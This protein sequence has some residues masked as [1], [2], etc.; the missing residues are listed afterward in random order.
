MEESLASKEKKMKAAASLLRDVEMSIPIRSSKHFQLSS[1]IDPPKKGDEDLVLLKKSDN[2]FL[3]PLDRTPYLT[4]VISQLHYSQKKPNIQAFVD[5]RSKLRKLGVKFPNEKKEAEGIVVTMTKF[6]EELMAN[7]Y[8]LGNVEKGI[9]V[10]KSTLDPSV[11]SLKL[12]DEN[13]NI[14]FMAAI[15]RLLCDY[16]TIINQPT[17]TRPEGYFDYYSLI[18]VGQKKPAE[19]AEGDSDISDDDHEDKK[20]N[21]VSRPPR[22]NNDDIIQAFIEE[23]ALNKIEPVTEA[24]A[25]KFV[26]NLAQFD[27]TFGKDLGVNPHYTENLVKAVELLIR[28]EKTNDEIVGPL[29]AFLDGNFEALFWLIENREAIMVEVAEVQKKTPKE[30]QANKDQSYASVASNVIITKGKKKKDAKESVT[31]DLLRRLGVGGETLE[32]KADVIKEKINERRAQEATPIDELDEEKVDFLNAGAR[33][34]STKYGMQRIE[35]QEFVLFDVK[36]YQKSELYKQT[37]RAE[38]KEVFPPYL[39]D[40]F[41]DGPTLNKLQT[42]IHKAMFESDEN[43]LC[44]APTGAGKTN[45]ALMGILRSLNRNFNPQT[46]AIGE[47]FRV[48]YISPLKALATELV[49]KFSKKLGHLGVVVRELT[50]DISLTKKEIASSHIIVSTPEKWDVVTR[51]SEELNMIFSVLIIDEIHLLDDERGRTL[52]CLVARTLQLTEN[53]QV[54]VRLIG[55]SATLPNFKDIAR[56]L[57]VNKNGLFFFDESFRPV[58]LHKKFI[59]VKKIEQIDRE[60]SR[61]DEEA[62]KGNS[63]KPKITRLDY[64]NILAYDTAIENLRNGKQVL[65]FVHSRKETVKMA[66]FMIQK[67]VEKG[68]LKLL[69]GKS[70]PLLSK[71]AENRDLKTLVDKGV[72]C[73]NAGLKRKDRHLIEKAFCNGELTVVVC[74]ATLA[75]GINMPCHCVIIKGTDFYQPGHG[76]TPISLLDVQQIFGRAG[77]PQFDDRGLA[78]LITKSEDLNY[79]VSMLSYVKPI[80]SH[81]LPFM[82]D[83]ILAEIVLGNICSLSEAIDYIKNTFFYVRY[84]K[85]PDKYGRKPGKDPQEF[86]F[87]KIFTT[88]ENLH[89]LRLIR[90]DPTNNVV[91]HT[92]L[93]RIASHYYVSCQTMEKLCN[94]LAVYEEDDQK[95]LWEI[96]ENNLLGIIAQANEF[97]QI[98]AKPDEE[99]ELGKLKK[100]FSHIEVD[101]EFKSL[102]K[103]T[104]TSAQEK[105]GSTFD[106]LEKVILLMWGYFNGVRYDN[107]SLTADTMYIVQNG[108]RI[109]RCLLDIAIMQNAASLAETILVVT[110]NLENCVGPDQTPLRMFCLDNYER[111]AVAMKAQNHEVSRMNY[112]QGATCLKLETFGQGM[113]NVYDVGSMRD[114]FAP[115]FDLH[116]PE[117]QTKLLRMAVNAFPLLDIEYEVKPIAQS[118]LEVTVY[119]KPMLRHNRPWH[120]G[121]EVVW[122]LAV[123]GREL[124]HHSQVLINPAESDLRTLEEVGREHSIRHSFFLPYKDGRDSYLVKFLSDRFIECDFNIEIDLKSLQLSFGKMEFTDLLDLEPLRPSALQEPRFEVL[125]DPFVRFFNPVQTQL[126][127]PLYHSDENI[128]V[129]APTGSGKTVLAELTILRLMRTKPGMKAVYVAPYKALVKE[130]LKDWTVRFAELGKKVEELSG[131]Y[132]PDTSALRAADLLLT[133]PEKWDGVTRGWEDKSFVSCVGLVVFDEIHLLGQDRGPTIEVIVARMNYMA[134]KTGRNVRLVGLSTA[135]ANGDDIA[136]WF[137]VKPGYMFNFRPNVRPV[138]VEIHFRG[139]TEKQY[140]PRMN[141]MNK[142]AYN[143]IRKLSPGAP[144]L[145]FVS[146]RRQT[147]LTAIDLISLS[148]AEASGRGGFLRMPEE[149]MEL[150][151]AQV[152]D[153]ILRQT[154]AFGVGVHHAGLQRGDRAIVEELFVN[155]KI[156]ILVATSTLAWGVNFPA[157]LVIVKGTEFF[158]PKTR[159]YVDMPITDILQMIG[160]AGRPQFNEKGFACVYVEGSKKNFYRK[161]IND[162]FPLESAFAAVLPEHLNAEVVSNTIKNKQECVDYLTWTYFFRRV[163]RNPSFYGLPNSSASEVQRFVIAAIDSAVAELKEAGCIEVDEDEFGLSATPIGAIGSRYYLKPRSAGTLAKLARESLSMPELFEGICQISEYTD[164]PVRHTEDEMNSDLNNISPIKLQKADFSTGNTKAFLLYMAYFFDLPLPIRDYATDTKLVLDNSFRIISAFA[165]LCALS[166]NLPNTLLSVQALQMVSQGRWISQ[167]ALANLPGFSDE[168]IAELPQDMQHLCQLQALHAAS[169]LKPKLEKLKNRIQADE[170]KETLSI[171]AKLPLLDIEIDLKK[172]DSDSQEVD[173]KSGY[174]FRGGE[175]ARLS[176]SFTDA[177]KQSSNEVV[178]KKFAKH[179]KNSWW[180]LAGLPEINTLLAVKRVDINR[181]RKI[182]LQIELPEASR[183][184]GILEI[185]VMS[186]SYIGIDQIKSIDLQS[187]RTS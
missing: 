112:L 55:L 44:C 144:A 4:S 70:S 118:I 3:M 18:D 14:L 84:L 24:E 59:G 90:F 83:A 115:V 169:Q 126:F 78:V 185:Y 116:L 35:K 175:E 22:L 106:S 177:N 53:K 92:E 160:R 157:K 139:F 133:T 108:S 176:L 46:K 66:T 120:F 99:E 153:P 140:C 36:P 93:G 130:R 56:F 40:V 143:D 6:I 168:L 101:M 117:A 74:T 32:D 164:V 1:L 97:E 110:R 167:S 174:R 158:D 171:I 5:L 125:F 109:I 187:F 43:I 148:A 86:L 15:D 127:W 111:S 150:V 135:V 123:D 48:V 30:P 20:S 96:S 28:P 64:M 58:P 57:N 73:H 9:E 26:S 142:P 107:Y 119:I 156:L 54:R 98:S 181:S 67:A 50:G 7:G 184:L 41:N 85:N 121:R 95:K 102:H 10:L 8:V 47:N 34:L 25:P 68:E 60:T 179:K 79:F 31:I 155:S 152:S 172:I 13:D 104:K 37:E 136:S 162:A 91:E 149:E 72:G 16:L 63:K 61:R 71:R 11:F 38:V 2:E 82:E 170:L 77:R 165:D 27:N 147:R 62:G 186:D 182:D 23:D 89:T 151:L 122:V 100:Q 183:D 113:M 49:N 159:G 114:N 76:Y 103:S 87:D 33:E 146:S 17:E 39:Q 154:L 132:S 81:F 105:G 29:E 137:G 163:V 19:E 21:E 52:E 145:I 173:P 75:W 161:Y 94:Y 134:R 178:M 124:L 65:I 138:P 166:K 69:Q 141:S 180:I 12:D 129:G 128:I 42:M 51:K 131:D 80:E 45:V 88:L